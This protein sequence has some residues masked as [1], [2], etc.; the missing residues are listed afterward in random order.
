M[1]ADLLVGIVRAAGAIINQAMKYA[2]SESVSI[3]DKAKIMAEIDS[4]R[5]SVED[6][7]KAEL[8]V[9]RSIKRKRDASKNTDK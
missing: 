5:Q 4:I 3:L 9:L 6:A 7:R 2:D 8:N 1:T